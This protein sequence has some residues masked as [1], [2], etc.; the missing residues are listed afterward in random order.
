MGDVSG[1]D[2]RRRHFILVCNHPPRSTQPFILSRSIN[3]VVSCNR[4]FCFLA[5]AA[6]SGECLR[7][8]GLLWL[9]AAVVWVVAAA[10]HSRTIGSCQWGCIVQCGWSRH[11]RVSS[12]IDESDL[13]LLP[14]CGVSS[15]F[16]EMTVVGLCCSFRILQSATL[17]YYT[18]LCLALMERRFVIITSC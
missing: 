17:N 13:Y 2:S 15:I 1:F 7:G 16:V 10:L 14:L 4:M 18:W 11:C 6:P 9:I 3:W 5:R 8:E 12:A